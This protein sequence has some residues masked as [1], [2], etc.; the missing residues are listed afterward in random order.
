MFSGS[1]KLKIFFCLYPLYQSLKSLAT[2]YTQVKIYK[3]GKVRSVCFSVFH[4][5][6][7]EYTCFCFTFQCHGFHF[8]FVILP[9]IYSCYLWKSQ[10]G[11][12]FVSHIRSRGLRYIFKV[13][14]VGGKIKYKYLKCDYFNSEYFANQTGIDIKSTD[15]KNVKSLN[16]EIMSICCILSPTVSSSMSLLTVI[17]F[18]SLKMT[19]NVIKAIIF[20]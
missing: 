19:C 9:R 14:K 15:V 2:A 3:S 16:R 8:R 4:T 6:S 11:R 7:L 18:C 10:P 17:I 20:S 12:R 13:F 1:S 5:T